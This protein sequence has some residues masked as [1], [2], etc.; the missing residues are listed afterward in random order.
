MNANVQRHHTTA[1]EKVHQRIDILAECCDA[2]L[3][4]SMTAIRQLVTRVVA[5]ERSAR[6]DE[7]RR[8]RVYVDVAD[9]ILTGRCRDLG[10]LFRLTL[11]QR[12]RWLVT[13]HLPP[14]PAPSP[15]GSG[16]IPT[17]CIQ[18]RGRS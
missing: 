2:E 1:I 6:E 16:E 9:D 3:V 17:H 7:M 18:T 8:Q 4:E 14:D 11:W 5:E 10:R 12:L 13:G 15:N